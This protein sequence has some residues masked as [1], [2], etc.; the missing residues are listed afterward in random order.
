MPARFDQRAARAKASGD[1]AAYERFS[2]FRDAFALGGRVGSA[3]EKGSSG[4]VPVPAA[5]RIVPD[6]AA[7][8]GGGATSPAQPAGVGGGSGTGSKSVPASGGQP[9]LLP[10]PV[11]QGERRFRAGGQSPAR[12]GWVP[13]LN[14]QPRPIR[15]ASR[16]P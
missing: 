5:S 2:A 4:G 16:R 10:P 15:Q 6:P 7:D 11:C 1:N 13:V 3:E 12:P 8:L 14:S 9:V